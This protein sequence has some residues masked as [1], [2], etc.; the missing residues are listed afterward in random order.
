MGFEFSAND[1]RNSLGRRSESGHFI[2]YYRAEDYSAEDIRRIKAV[3]EYH[4]R[5]VSDA[6]SFHNGSTDKISVYIYPDNTWKQRYIGTANTNIAKPWKREIHL[7]TATFATTFRHELVH[8]LAADFGMPVIKASLRMAL[9]EGLAVAVDWEEGLFTPHQFA[10]AIQREH[11]LENVPQLFSY[12]GFA[13][14]SSGYA[15][16]VAGSFSR[17]LLDRYGIHRF[18]RVFPDGNFMGTFG[19]SL[20][21]LVKDWKAFLKTV[22]ASD[23]PPET[24]Q[25]IFFQ[26][27]I[28]YKTCAREVA[29]RSQRAVQAIRMKD[30][31]LAENEFKASYKNAPTAYALRGLFQSLNSQHRP[32]DVIR[33][34]SALP[35]HSMLR[36]NPGVLLLLGDAQ[37]LNGAPAAAKDIYRL[38]WQMNYSEAFIEASTVRLQS[39]EDHIDPSTF[40]ALY[41]GG[42]EDSAKATLVRNLLAHHGDAAVLQYY[43][44][45]FSRDSVDPT[46][47]RDAMPAAKF[48]SRDISYFVNVRLA[49]RLFSQNHFEEAKGFY[50]LAKNGTPTPALTEYLD[51]RIELCDFVVME[52]Q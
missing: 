6:L 3:A 26:P 48:V 27:S 32:V 28:F 45:V 21:S 18:R 1:I 4:Y 39:V 31:R 23:I 29:E 37:Y 49:D 20:E 35:E 30:Y 47:F 11:G 7:T 36:S 46:R 9:N 33:S 44:T 2:V 14:Q 19:E 24:I 50:W 8:I 16:I 43:Y 25:S 51:D 52:M 41:Y 38:V 34:F 42:L 10:A 17:Y 5:K 22:D 13:T 40:H 15:Y 12:T